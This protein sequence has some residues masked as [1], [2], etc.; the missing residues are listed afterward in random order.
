MRIEIAK[1]VAAGKTGQEIL[2]AYVR[3]YGNRVLVDPRTIPAWWTAWIPWF[4]LALGA[5]LAIWILNRWRSNSP[6]PAQP[7]NFDG[8]ALPDI[9]DED[10]P[11]SSA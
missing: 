7:S 10:L 6:S 3:Q 5:T 11:G 9:E 1:W 4:A 8:G 2:D